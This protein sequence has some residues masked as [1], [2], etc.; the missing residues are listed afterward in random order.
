MASSAVTFEAE[1]VTGVVEIAARAAAANVLDLAA[2]LAVVAA[3]GTPVVV[4]AVMVD[5]RVGRVPITTIPHRVVALSLRLC[6]DQRRSCRRFHS[7]PRHL[8]TR[9]LKA[10]VETGRNNQP[11]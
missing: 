2:V 3:A 4:A 7:R 8:P 5:L 1:T 11:C 6:A 10:A 9:S